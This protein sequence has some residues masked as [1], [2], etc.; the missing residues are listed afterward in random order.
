MEC[1]FFDLYI[2]S[3]QSIAMDT[4]KKHALVS[5]ESD[6][7]V[8]L[9]LV[10]LLSRLERPAGG[11]MTEDERRSVEEV[12]G[13]SNQVCKIIEILRGK[14]NRD[15][16]AFLKMLRKSGN[17]LWAGKIDEESTHQFEEYHKAKG[18]EFPASV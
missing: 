4:W 11:F 13:K 9:S 10:G 7:K 8:N 14:G 2:Y 6:L 12:Q 18:M 3:S 17:E 5:L 15:F 1:P 16:D